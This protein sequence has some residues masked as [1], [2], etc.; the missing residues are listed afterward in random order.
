MSMLE[1]ENLACRYDGENVIDDLS[2]SIEHNEI[3]ALLGPS[4]CGK[5]TLL[6]AIAGLQRIHA[7]EIRIK[8][9][10][11]SSATSQVPSQQ[12]HVGMIFQDYALFPH[13]TVAQNIG[14]GIRDRDSAAVKASVEE[15]LNLVKLD[16]LGA[17]YPHELSGGQQQRVAI[18]RALAFEPDLMLLDEPFS[19]IDSQSR[20]SI[21]AEIRRILKARGVA[22]VFVTHSKDE[23]FAFADRLAVFESGK[24]AQL[25]SAE[26]LYLQPSSSYVASFLGKTNYLAVESRGEDRVETPLGPVRSSQPLNGRANDASMLML[27]PEQLRLNNDSEGPIRV[28]D[29]VFGGSQWCYHLA[30]PDAD[31]PLLEAWSSEHFPVGSQLSVSVSP[32]P[33][34]LF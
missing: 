13:L 3:V 22:A 20:A 34:V 19:N 7:G 21:M 9:R 32:H 18:A 29:A 27:R 16:G 11:V 33:L 10:L 25:G 26:E 6:R 1:I 8:D 28:V 5:T 2:L 23:A 24:I 14:F 31:A 17:R 4:G 12:R 15:M 30:L